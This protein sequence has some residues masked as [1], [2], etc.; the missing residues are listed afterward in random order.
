MEDKIFQSRAEVKAIISPVVTVSICTGVIFFAAIFFKNNLAFD[1]KM[2][3]ATIIL[4]SVLI[5]FI[6]LIL[7]WA[8]FI[9]KVKVFKDG[10]SSYNP[11]EALKSE[12]LIWSE[13][14]SICIKSVLGYKYYF[15]WSNDSGK[16]LW[17]PYMI[18]NKEHFKSTVLS[19][20]D[21]NH[22]FAKELNKT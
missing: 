2:L 16:Q 11:Y 21:S 18:K 13:M 8:T 15:L 7:S 22:I 9:N 17:I 10:I 1:L 6:T 14:Q 20:L 19:Q 4:L 3:K 5:P 12:F